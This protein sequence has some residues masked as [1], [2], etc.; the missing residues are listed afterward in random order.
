MLLHFISFCSC[1]EPEKKFN[2]E[3]DSFP[4]SDQIWGMLGAIMATVAC[5]IY[6]TKVNKIHI[7]LEFLN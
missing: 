7:F 3:E 2:V 5:W 6:H 1:D 4:S